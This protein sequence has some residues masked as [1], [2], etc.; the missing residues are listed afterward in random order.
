MIKNLRPL[1]ELKTYR[2]RKGERPCHLL[3]TQHKISHSMMNANADYL[4]V[5]V[6]AMGHLPQL[7]QALLATVNGTHTGAPHD[8]EQWQPG[9]A[10]IGVAFGTAAGVYN[11]VHE[12]IHEAVRAAVPNAPPLAEPLRPTPV[13]RQDAVG[14]IHAPVLVAPPAAVK[15]GG[16]Q[17]KLKKVSD[18]RDPTARRVAQEA[19][20]MAEYSAAA[21]GAVKKTRAARRALQTTETKNLPTDTCSICADLMLKSDLLACKQC[22]ALACGDCTMRYYGRE[23]AGE[24]LPKCATCGLEATFQTVRAE[25]ILFNRKCT[26]GDT[27]R[28]RVCEQAVLREKSLLVSTESIVGFYQGR[29]NITHHISN[30]AND[31]KNALTDLQTKAR[32]IN[33]PMIKILKLSRSDKFYNGLANLVETFKQKGFQPQINMLQPL[34]AIILDEIFVLLE[35]TIMKA[36]YEKDAKATP[37]NLQFSIVSL[38]VL[39]SQAEFHY[40]I[41]S[42]AVTSPNRSTSGALTE[43]FTTMVVQDR[44]TTRGHTMVDIA[45]A[46]SIFAERRKAVTMLHEFLVFLPRDWWLV[47]SAKDLNPVITDAFLNNQTGPFATWVYPAPPRNLMLSSGNEIERAC[48]HAP[49]CRGHMYRRPLVAPP[50]LSEPAAVAPSSGS[51]LKEMREA[52][53][54][55]LGGGAAAADVTPVRALGPPPSAVLACQMC[56]TTACVLCQCVYPKSA[57]KDLPTVA[58]EHACD[59]DQVKS[60][61]EIRETTRPCP[62]CGERITKAEGCR[63]MFC[64]RCKQ[65]FDW[66]TLERH[67]SNTNP[68]FLTWAANGRQKV[69]LSA[70]SGGYIHNVAEGFQA[71][72]DSNIHGEDSLT[73]Q[74]RLSHIREETRAAGLLILTALTQTLLTIETSGIQTFA[75][76][77]PTPKKFEELRISHLSDDISEAD[78]TTA[79]EMLDVQAYVYQKLIGIMEEFSTRSL[80]IIKETYQ[81]Y[82]TY[83]AVSRDEDQNHVLVNCKLFEVQAFLGMVRLALECSNNSKLLHIIPKFKTPLAHGLMNN[84]AKFYSDLLTGTISQSTGAAAAAYSTMDEVPDLPEHEI[85]ERALQWLD[86]YHQF[87]VD[88][89]GTDDQRFNALF[90]RIHRLFNI[91]IDRGTLKA[92]LCGSLPS[93]K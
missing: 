45:T 14:V 50:A 84:M 42:Q 66:E 32:A 5:L 35:D 17:A 51:S 52:R 57:Q 27:L 67:V 90:D 58:A 78:W 62:R 69:A 73:V 83:I 28:A 37:P 33:P 87:A 22:E 25:R 9:G 34:R 6:P 2:P 79:V 92:Q 68:H 72:F 1:S 47:G 89:R 44:S 71:V 31:F 60:I 36:P 85:Q 19:I 48:L 74:E 15:G 10:M 53:T 55:L 39:L 40:R 21:R 63:H 56:D 54:R 4:Q 23:N 11:A 64:L 41:L 8:L 12:A 75:L 20:F 16:F 76:D 43:L 65:A 38:A 18:I 91:T 77:M 26:I 80:E 7:A 3:L 82:K 30:V 61:T 93:S 70:Y 81:N 88:R 59:P 24:L 49:Q 86:N 46:Q 29:R 13:R